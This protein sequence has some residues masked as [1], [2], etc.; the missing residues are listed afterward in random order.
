MKTPTY[1]AFL[2]LCGLL[3][4][5]SGHLSAQEPSLFQEMGA[6]HLTVS[7]DHPELPGPVGFG[8]QSSWELGGFLMAR[9]SYHRV[10]EDTRK[11]GTVC[12]QYSQ[13]I[14]CRAEVTQTS[15]T[16]SGVRGALLFRFPFG[17]VVRLAAG[18]GLSFNHV[19]TEAVG[20]VS[21]LD[22]DL[23][24]PNAGI[25]GLTGLVTA[26]IHPLR[27]VPLKLTGGLGIHWAN[28]YTCSGNDPPQYD[29]YCGAE[30]F[31]EIELGLAFAFR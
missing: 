21:N 2:S 8:V 30:R 14:N 23:L 10:S 7:S 17:D 3:L 9:L 12:D 26:A 25:I 29:P 16:L 5:N 11:D 31:T 28:F 22:A 6:F 24:A 27:S 18:G 19:N 15:A 13:R 1:N 4:S 20:I